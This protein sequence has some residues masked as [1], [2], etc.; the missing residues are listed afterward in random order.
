MDYTPIISAVFWPVLLFAVLTALVA[1]L[2]PRFVGAIG[3]A[4]VS[5]KLRR[6]CA[7]VADDLILPDGRGGLTQ[8]DHLALT[9]TG[10]LVV[11]TTRR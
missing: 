5:R 3:E 6:Y 9:P 1:V 11:E 8:V 4:V 7:E 10:L 2:R